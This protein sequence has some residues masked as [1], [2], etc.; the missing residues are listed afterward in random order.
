MTRRSALAALAAL[1]VVGCTG[2]G[3]SIPVGPPAVL[4]ASSAA[5]D[6]ASGGGL[7]PAGELVGRVASFDGQGF[8]PAVGATVTVEGQN[9]TAT[10]DADGRFGFQQLPIGTVKLTASADGQQSFTLVCVLNGAAGLA[11]A[12]LALVPTARPAK[13]AGDAVAIAGVLTDPRGAGLPNGTVHAV[14]AVSNNGKGGNQQ[15]AADADGFFAYVMPAVGSRNLAGGQAQLSG[16][17]ITPGGVHVETT[18]ILTTLVDTR[19]I[20]NVAVGAVAFTSV[21]QPQWGGGIGRTCTITAQQ[22]PT[23]RDELVLHFEQNGRS[24]DVSPDSLSG[25]TLSFTLPDGIQ[26]G[27]GTI[28]IRVFGL[29]PA[30][31]I[32]IGV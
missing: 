17:G 3:K 4:S 31:T 9:L 2:K 20:Q 13:L 14:D 16:F 18:D 19:P 28:E 32:N 30:P 15:V 24:A 11:R 1:L 26:A 29:T 10:T 21:N 7:L 27:S 5:A 12:N 22:L 8:V 23:R 6:A 25:D